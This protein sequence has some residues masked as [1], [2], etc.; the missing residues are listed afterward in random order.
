MGL[1]KQERETARKRQRGGGREGGRATEIE[2]E[3][4]KE[5]AFLTQKLMRFS[6]SSFSFDRRE[7]EAFAMVDEI[8]QR[9]HRTCGMVWGSVLPPNKTQV[10]VVD[11]SSWARRVFVVHDEGDVRVQGVVSNLIDT[12]MR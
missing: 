5:I 10:E 3:R 4:Q 9:S 7:F 1:T 2:T 8:L 11:A 6:L 12:M